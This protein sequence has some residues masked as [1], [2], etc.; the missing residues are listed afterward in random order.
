MAPQAPAPASQDWSTQFTPSLLEVLESFCTVAVRGVDPPNCNELGG[1]VTLTP[2]NC[3]ETEP[4]IILIC[5]LIDAVEAQTGYPFTG[6]DSQVGVA[7]TV[8][9]MPSEGT[10][11]GAV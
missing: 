2:I 9:T 5:A 7:V 10:V 11:A 4:D 8:T 3:C 6:L 1:S